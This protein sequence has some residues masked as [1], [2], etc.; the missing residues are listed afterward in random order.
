MARSK[1]R[2]GR[3]WRRLRERVKR[4]Q[5][6]CWIC[7]QPIDKTLVW[8]DPQSFSVDHKEPLSLRPELARVYSNLAA[9][10]LGCNSSRN[11]GASTGQP[12]SRIW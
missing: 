5:S 10:H 3:P 9:A 2:T 1:G 4:N 6:T 8:P 11:T 7:G 12:Q